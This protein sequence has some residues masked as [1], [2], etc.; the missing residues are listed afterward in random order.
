M[1]RRRGGGGHSEKADIL[2]ACGRGTQKQ[3][4]DKVNNTDIQLFTVAVVLPL[5][6]SRLV[7]TNKSLETVS[8]VPF[9]R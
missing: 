8:L 9:Y 4:E 6:S 1:I 3:L 5:T 2:Q 7:H